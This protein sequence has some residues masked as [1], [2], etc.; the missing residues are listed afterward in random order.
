MFSEI[1]EKIKNKIESKNMKIE[2]ITDNNLSEYL[3]GFNCSNCHN[4]CSLNNIKCGGGIKARE[5][6]IEEYN[7]QK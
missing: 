4:R 6:K 5:E 2:E 1:K 3:S 7:K